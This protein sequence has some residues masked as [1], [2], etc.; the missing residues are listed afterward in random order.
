MFVLRVTISCIDN[1]QLVKVIILSTRKMTFVLKNLSNQRKQN[2]SCR[3]NF[4]TFVATK[5]K[6]TFLT[7]TIFDK[8]FLSITLLESLN[9]C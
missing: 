1:K 4:D 9:N 8:Y 5:V 2:W 7:L 6:P 3:F